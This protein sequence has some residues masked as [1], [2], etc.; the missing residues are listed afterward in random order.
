MRMLY[1]RKW[2]DKSIMDHILAR[3]KVEPLH[4]HCYV[5]KY[6][7]IHA[8]AC[9]LFG[10]WKNAIEACGIDYS[11]VRKYRE[12]SVKKILEEIKKASKAK[13][14]LNSKYIQDNNRPLYMAAIKRFKS[15]GK[16]VHAAGFDYKKIRLRRNMEPAEIKKEIQELYKKGVDLAY[17]FMRENYQ[18]L[19]AN[20]MKKIGDGSWALARK[21][22]GILENYRLSKHKR[23]IKAAKKT[24]LKTV[25]KNN[26]KNTK[27]GKNNSKGKRK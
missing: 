5:N 3:Y 15:W 6:P 27:P 1:H 20:G 19:L 4:H 8:A 11:E 17:P 22:S 23:K 26:K 14:S 7:D 16:A 12:W 18:Y 10:S 13:K 24:T 2:D 21:K 25:R 9:R